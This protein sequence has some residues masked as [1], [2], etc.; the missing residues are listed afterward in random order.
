MVFEDKISVQAVS[1][2][3]LIMMFSLVLIIAMVVLGLSSYMIFERVVTKSTL[4]RVQAIAEQRRYVIEDYLEDTR[5]AV[6]QLARNY[7]WVNISSDYIQREADG[8]L[9]NHPRGKGRHPMVTT[10]RAAMLEGDFYDFFLITP[11]GRV[12][13]SFKRQSDFGENVIDGPLK[14]TGLGQVYA[15]INSYGQIETSKLSYYAPSDRPAAF[16]ASGIYTPEGEQIGVVAIELSVDRL[17]MATADF[18]QLGSTG[19]VVLATQVN[20]KPMAV[21][22]LRHAPEAAFDPEFFNDPSG[23][24]PISRAL[25]GEA[26][27]GKSFDYR[28]VPIVVSWLPLAYGD[29]GMVVK[30]DY[31]EIMQ[32]LQELQWS[33]FVVA[34]VTLALVVLLTRLIASVSG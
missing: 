16:V 2:R 33:L 25:K 22:P 30:V 18:A 4:L 17:A 32:P 24:L 12:V 29:L 13:Y 6:R 19:E 21:T 9:D 7:A 20:G 11:E 27:V 14:D 28:G 34:V 3:V 5:Q 10:A 31:A 26:G 15:A 8:T 23:L 1:P